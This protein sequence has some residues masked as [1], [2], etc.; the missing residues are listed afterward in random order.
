MY[1]ANQKLANWVG[2]QRRSYRDAVE[3]KNDLVLKSDRIKKLNDLGFIWYVGKGN[4]PLRKRKRTE[5]SEHVHLNS[6]TATD[7]LV[8][9]QTNANF[10]LFNSSSHGC[11]A[12]D[13]SETNQS[14]KIAMVN[15][16]DSS[17]EKATIEDNESLAVPTGDEKSC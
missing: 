14:N 4:N 1:R 16:D 9:D 2:T 10:T 3:F 17:K 15:N 8:E 13:E 12:L 6:S 5:L 7:T 11:I